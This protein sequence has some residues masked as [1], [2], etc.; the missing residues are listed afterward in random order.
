[1]HGATVD[2]A[3]SVSGGACGADITVRAQAA[4]LSEVLRQVAKGTGA[5][6]SE[7]VVLADRV[8]FELTGTPESVLKRLMANRN[9]VLETGEAKGCRGR[10]TVTKIWVLPAG[11]D[12]VRASAPAAGEVEFRPMNEPPPPKQRRRT[13]ERLTGKDWKRAHAVQAEKA[14]A[15]PEAKHEPEQP[16]PQE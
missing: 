4:P 11:E 10:Q 13:G 14:P 6:L 15:E 1:M 16:K 2:G 7:K 3:V 12:R 5:Q 9:L 8:T